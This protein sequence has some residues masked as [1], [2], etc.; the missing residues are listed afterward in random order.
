M[1]CHALISCFC[2]N[3]NSNASEISK[4]EFKLGNNHE[5]EAKLYISYLD[6]TFRDKA[7]C[8]MIII[9]E[10]LLLALCISSVRWTW[11]GNLGLLLPTDDFSWGGG[12]KRYTSLCSSL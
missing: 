12:M 4:H 8:H 1:Y 7:F 9:Q 6:D 11:Y 5:V 10:V 3:L 2:P